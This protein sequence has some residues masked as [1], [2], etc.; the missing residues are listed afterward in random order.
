MALELNDDESHFAFVVPCEVMIAVALETSTWQ[1]PNEYIGSLS[2]IASQLHC[3][4]DNRND[5][6]GV[7]D[8]ARVRR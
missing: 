3:A 8:K 6:I 1:S 4:R 7:D 5:P 2:R